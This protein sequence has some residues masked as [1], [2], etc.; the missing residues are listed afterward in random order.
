MKTY[1]QFSEEQ[2]M[3][4]FLHALHQLTNNLGEIHHKSRKNP[5]VQE[6]CQS[7]SE[8]AVSIREWCDLPGSVM[9]VVAYQPSLFDDEEFGRGADWDVD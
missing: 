3:K 4:E 7:I 9:L 1:S 2:A 6:M 5:R 8:A